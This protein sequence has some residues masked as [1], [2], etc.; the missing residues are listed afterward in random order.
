M[1]SARLWRSKR[2]APWRT[3]A[4]QALRALAA[5]LHA[6]FP[7]RAA[8]SLWHRDAPRS[9]I[10]PLRELGRRLRLGCDV[11]SAMHDLESVLG[12]EARTLACVLA[13]HGRM[14]GDLA[15][16]IERL[17][18]ASEER[19]EAIAAGRAAG[20]GALLSGRIVAGLP[21]LLVPFAPIAGSPLFDP[22][23]L[24]MLCIGGGLAVSGM[25][26]V[27][28]LVP[29]PPSADPEG[30]V[31][32]EVLACVL[33]GGA[34]VHAALTAVSEIGLDDA[35]SSLTEA[36]RTVRL[37]A[38]W[39]DALERTGDSS[40]RAISSE[41]RRTFVLGT[42]VSAA[43]KRWAQAQRAASRREFDEAMRRAPVLMVV[44]LSVCV[45]PAYALLGLAPYLRG[46]L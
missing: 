7:S 9:L 10:G 1:A 28:R 26:W 39:P 32:A 5:L 46:L 40:L 27:S 23:G 36:R 44:P 22:L 33:D 43:L 2:L 30:V 16:M 29:V 37:G 42:P 6:G 45:L 12:A 8:L 21:L 18:A 19:V 41:L 15:P 34:P 14:G 17:A 31:L 25:G 13:V 20:A 3:D 4:A 35:P 24:L 38:S 11:R